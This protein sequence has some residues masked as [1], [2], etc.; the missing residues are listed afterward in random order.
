M[1]ARIIAGVCTAAFAVGH[2]PDIMAH[3]GE[4]HAETAPLQTDILPGSIG[5]TAINPLILGKQDTQ[6]KA[7]EVKT[8]VADEPAAIG[9]DEDLV[10]V[11]KA[12]IE[13]YI[14]LATQLALE[15]FKPTPEEGIFYP[16]C[17]NEDNIRILPAEDPSRPK[18]LIG[19]P[20]D[21]Y[22]PKDM[23]TPLDDPEITIVNAWGRNLTDTCTTD[24]LNV[25]NPGPEGDNEQ[26]NTVVE[27][28]MH[29]IK[30]RTKE[31]GRNRSMVY[32]LKDTAHDIYDPKSPIYIGANSNTLPE[33]AIMTIDTQRHTTDY[34]ADIYKEEIP[35]FRKA[36]KFET[37]KAVTDCETV[38]SLRSICYVHD[39]GVK[40]RVGRYVRFRSH[41]TSKGRIQVL[42][43]PRI[44]PPGVL[45]RFR[46]DGKHAISK[47]I[48]KQERRLTSTT[49]R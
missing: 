7:I 47:W 22:P 31:P 36:N 15:R 35:V 6:N 23:R 29:K 37:D 11:T 44:V 27:E 41:H 16:A 19:T 30:V 28:I 43:K 32:P 1:R 12:Q 2:S 48:E 49:R 34:L 21:E 10:P 3:G 18:E 25:K 9:P 13:R 40:Y 42:E 38:R 14:G 45:Q 24:Y 26:C 20:A 8:S 39:K 46:R 4:L 5:H 17:I 33:C